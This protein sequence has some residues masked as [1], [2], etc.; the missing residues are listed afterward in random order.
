MCTYHGTKSLLR[1]MINRVAIGRI[2]P[3]DRP[4]IPQGRSYVSRVSVV[5]IPGIG[6]HKGKAWEGLLPGSFNASY[7]MY[8]V[9]S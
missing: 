4:Y 7:N 5:C 1:A 6:T 9:P 8:K 2:Y 3:G